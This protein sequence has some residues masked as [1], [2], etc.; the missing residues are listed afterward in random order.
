MRRIA[1]LISIAAAWGCAS[2]AREQPLPSASSEGTDS[3]QKRSDPAA[4][5]DGDVTV[6]FANGVKVIVKRIP[7]AE[8]VATQLNILGGVRNWGEDDAGIEQLALST[9]A[10]GGTES[11]DKDAF[12]RRLAGLGS[13]IGAGALNDFSEF[14]AKCLRQHWDTTF[15]LMADAFL[16]PALPQSEVDLQR[17]NQISALR[18]QMEDPDGQLS[19]LV[20]QTLFKGHPYANRAVGTIETVSQLK[21]EQLRDYLRKLRE[22]RRLLLVVVG[23]IEPQHVIDQARGA[24]GALPSGTY[25]NTA[26]PPLSFDHPTV[27]TFPR[28]LPTNYIVSTFL[29]PGWGDPDFPSAMAAMTVLGWREWIEVR[30]KRNLSY[31]PSASLSANTAVA[32]G[33]LYV[34]AVDPDATMRVMFEQARKLRAETVPIRELEGDTSF[35]LTGFLMSSEN[36]DGQAAQLSRAEILGGDWHLARTLPERMR[37]VTPQDVEAFAKKYIANLQTVVLGD[38]EKID[39]SLF[40]SL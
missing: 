36:T 6:G 25:R 17:Q 2:S 40:S 8:L 22:T 14:G 9:S 38:P 35:F 23:D 7:G 10:S 18:H 33:T 29:A 11:L 3:S 19:L 26:L 1:A 28:K 30:T 4:I 27:V 39:P 37:A 31:A 16:R 32:R 15:G 20:Q 12:A 24:F 21:T 13:A 5:A 34:T